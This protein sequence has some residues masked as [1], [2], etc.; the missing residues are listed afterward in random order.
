MSAKYVC[1]ACRRRFLRERDLV[2]HMGTPAH[3][4]GLKR[5]EVSKALKRAR[6]AP[7]EA[8][9]AARGLLEQEAAP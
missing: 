4:E 9:A 7:P 3:Q 1:E 2:Q 6:R 8:N 5:A